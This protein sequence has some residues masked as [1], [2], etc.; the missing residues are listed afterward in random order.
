MK[1]K[2]YYTVEL[3]TIDIDG[4][5]ECNG[6]KTITVYTI[7]NNEPKQWFDIDCDCSDNS[8]ESIN[9]YLNDNGYEDESFD[10][11]LL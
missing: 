6:N 11:V 5:I 4:T 8:K 7:E 10:I 3:E 1:R 2:I 9:D